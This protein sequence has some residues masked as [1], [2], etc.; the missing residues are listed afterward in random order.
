MASPY[1]YVSDPLYLNWELCTV[2]HKQLGGFYA[3][4][5]GYH[6]IP[7]NIRRRGKYDYS[8]TL[9][10]DTSGPDSNAAGFDLTLPRTQMIQVTTRLRQAVEHPQDNRLNC[11]REFYGTVNGSTVFGRIHD[12]PTAN[13]RTSSADRSHLWHVHIGF[14]RSYVTDSVAMAG[15]V[16]VI[17]GV[18]WEDWKE[19]KM[20]L[21]SYGDEGSIVEYFQRKL[22]ALGYDPGPYDGIFGAKTRDANYKFRIDNGIDPKKTSGNNITA[23]TALKMEEMF[24]KKWIDKYGAAPV[25]VD[26]KKAVE[27]HWNKHKHE[28]IGPQGPAGK[29]PDEF[30]IIGR[31]ERD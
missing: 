20:D 27:E 30:Q 31:F 15:V 16:S 21:P 22:N 24:I 25:V 26:V 4:K 11:V 1:Q 19:V 10:Y 13:W 8:Y 17:N 7:E 6:D 3:A 28:L 5:G 12:A 23:W 9:T 2:P 14:F 18:S 29:V